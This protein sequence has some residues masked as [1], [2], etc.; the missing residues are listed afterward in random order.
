MPPLPHAHVFIPVYFIYLFFYAFTIYVFLMY[1]KPVP[2]A[3]TYLHT[4][5]VFTFT[6]LIAW[7]TLCIVAII[8]LIVDV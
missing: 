5:F 3:P 8:V 2:D 7:I 4:C 6:T 1:L